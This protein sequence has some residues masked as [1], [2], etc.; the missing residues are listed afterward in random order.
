M[1]ADVELT[2]LL[3]SSVDSLDLMGEEGEAMQAY[4]K[5]LT[6]QGTVPNIFIQGQ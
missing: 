1:D 3:F 5:T 4:L 2:S 6:G